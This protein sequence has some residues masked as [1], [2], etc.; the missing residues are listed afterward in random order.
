MNYQLDY[1]RFFPMQL[2]QFFFGLGILSNAEPEDFVTVDGTDRL[3]RPLEGGGNGGAGYHGSTSIQNAGGGGGGGG[4]GGAAEELFP[5][6]IGGNGGGG[7]GGGGGGAADRVVEFP[8]SGDLISL[9][10]IGED[11]TLSL[12]DR[13]PDV[14]CFCDTSSGEL[15]NGPP[16]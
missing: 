1:D 9:L 15:S 11:N 3:S 7:G 14:L 4:G 16:N 2:F 6:K 10:E 5:P 8:V 13:S 12:S